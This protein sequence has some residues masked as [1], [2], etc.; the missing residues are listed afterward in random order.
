M[1]RLPGFALQVRG[2]VAGFFDKASRPVE[3]L[4]GIHAGHPAG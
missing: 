4:A 1:T 2:W 3:K